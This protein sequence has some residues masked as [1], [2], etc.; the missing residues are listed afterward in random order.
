MAI[1][2]RRAGASPFYILR[3]AA[4]ARARPLMHGGGSIVDA[5]E[6]TADFTQSL[7][8]ALLHCIV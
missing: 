8:N 7:L 3:R 1:Q 2:L 4:I 5:A 6:R